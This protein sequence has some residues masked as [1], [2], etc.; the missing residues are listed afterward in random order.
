MVDWLLDRFEM[1]PLDRD[2]LRRA[3]ALKANDYEDAVVAALAEGCGCD[4][5]VTRN[6]GDYEGLP[7]RAIHPVDFLTRFENET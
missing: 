1:P 3:R 7:V 6:V 5:I 4:G 2:T